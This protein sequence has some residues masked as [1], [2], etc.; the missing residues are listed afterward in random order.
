MQA[1]CCYRRHRRVGAITSLFAPGFGIAQA[2]FAGKDGSDIGEIETQRGVGR[3]AVEDTVMLDFGRNHQHIC[4][5]HVEGK[6]GNA[7]LCR[8]QHSDDQLV[9]AGDSLRA[10]V[11][12]ADAEG[13]IADADMRQSAA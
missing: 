4:R 6:M 11:E 9:V 12:R 3:R 8:K 10:E 7:V 5:I 2:R 1:V 13:E